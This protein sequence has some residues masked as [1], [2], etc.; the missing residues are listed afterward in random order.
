MG[1]EYYDYIANNLAQFGCVLFDASEQPQFDFNMLKKYLISKDKAFENVYL[2]PLNVYDFKEKSLTTYFTFVNDGSVSP[3]TF[4]D[5]I[6]LSCGTFN[7][8]KFY[9]C[10][11]QTEKIYEI[12]PWS[13]CEY[14][15]LSAFK[16]LLKLGEDRQIVGKSLRWCGPPGYLRY[17]SHAR[18]FKNDTEREF[19]AQ[20]G[21][22]YSQFSTQKLK[23]DTFFSIEECLYKIDKNTN[24]LEFKN[25]TI[26]KFDIFDPSL[27]INCTSLKAQNLNVKN[28]TAEQELFCE[29]L[30]C[31]RLEGKKIYA[32]SIECQSLNAESIKTNFKNG[33]KFFMPKIGEE[34][35]NLISKIKDFK[36]G[37]KEILVKFVPD[38]DDPIKITVKTQKILLIF[39]LNNNQEEILRE[40]FNFDNVIV[41]EKHLNKEELRQLLT[42]KLNGA[43]ILGVWEREMPRASYFHSGNEVRLVKIL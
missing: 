33:I 14:G 7:L 20:Y 23:T 43:P 9:A 40:E 27:T 15:N 37:Y 42:E 36:C 12:S 2:F 1:I 31:D 32:E 39:G 16:N 25:R 22:Y 4:F 8:K 3:F 24:C 13:S 30:K 6:R 26:L 34:F 11:F 18:V 19:F 10:D 38:S 41:K 21:K 29:N 35:S 28:I 5:V 17:Y